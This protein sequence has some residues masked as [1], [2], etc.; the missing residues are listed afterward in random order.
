MWQSATK[1]NPD[2]AGCCTASP[3]HLFQRPLLD[4]LTTRFVGLADTAR[5]YSTEF[6]LQAGRRRNPPGVEHRARTRRG[7]S[8]ERLVAASRRDLAVRAGGRTLV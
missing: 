5:S 6:K 1:A 7:S 2:L 4:T 3:L 8:G